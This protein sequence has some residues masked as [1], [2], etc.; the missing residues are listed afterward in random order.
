MNTGQALRSLSGRIVRGTMGA[1]LAGLFAS[2]LDSAYARGAGEESLRGGKLVALLAADAGL[3][4]P[5]SLF[6]GFAVATAAVVVFP[7]RTP[8]PSMVIDELRLRS[9]GR[10]ADIA[11]FVPLAVFALFFWTTLS[12]QLARALLGLDM[13]APLLGLSVAVGSLVIGILAA[14]FALA[15]T[16]PLRQALA[17]ASEGRPGFVDPAKTGAV[18]IVLVLG[19]FALGIATGGV[20][21][22]GGLLGIWGVLKRPEL[23]LRAVAMLVVVALG[24]FF[25]SAL[26]MPRHGALALLVALTPTVLF[27]PRAALSL[28]GDAAPVAQALERGAPLGKMVLAGMR[29]VTDRDKDGASALFG[30]G[31][32]LEGDARIGPL[33]VE[34]PDNGIDE[35]CSGSDLRAAAI[36]ALNALNAPPSS[37]EASS[38]K[39]TAP[40]KA[41]ELPADL[42]VVLITIDTLR[43]DLGYAGYPKPVSPNIDGL[44]ARSTVFLRAYSLA[45]YTGKSIGPMLLGKYGSETDRNWGH[46]NKF[47]DQETFLAERVKA[48]GVHTMSVHGHRYFGKFGG[49]DRGFDEVDLSAAPP[50]GAPWDVADM[51]TSTRITDAALA[52]LAKP[53]TTSGRFFLWAHYL[54]P[55]ADY[56]KHD[57]VPSFGSGQRALYDGEI[58]FTDKHIGRLLAAIEAAPWGKRTAIVLTSDHGEAFGEHKMVRHGFELWEPLVHVPLIVYVPTSKPSRIETRR[59]AVDVTPTVLSLFRIDLPKAKN[60]TTGPDFLSGRSLLPDVFLPEG[61]APAERD[62]FVDMPAGPYNDARRA[63]FHGDLKLISSNDARFELYDLSRDPEEQKDLWSSVETRAAMADRYAAFRATLREI[64]VTGQRK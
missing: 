63:F 7:G 23:D 41:L 64:R 33:G 2:L 49:L 8:T 36:A 59:S 3:V 40:S 10:P 6:V 38:E 11:A 16:P 24:A 61:Q 27:L 28:G 21:G 30:G 47:S 62:I 51:E 22:E 37:S 5:V 55:H 56:L 13:A 58:A 46:F 50:E 35:D 60:E 52:K 15:L 12:A 57:D 34:I 1:S 19:L 53:E 42:N 18:A 4:A 29:K 14:L 43:A 17:T 31:D 32:C 54:D 25:S 9:K 39:G 20:S 48:A 44:A 26:L 45:S